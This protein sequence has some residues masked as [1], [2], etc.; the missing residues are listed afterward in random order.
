MSESE[1]PFVR[2]IGYYTIGLVIPFVFAR[3]IIT[4]LENVLRFDGI[5]SKSNQ[6]DVLSTR[7]SSP[8]NHISKVKRGLYGIIMPWWLIKL[9][10]DKK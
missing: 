1:M 7:I 2:R 5:F 8:I 9:L 6:R 3:P 4:L 10:F